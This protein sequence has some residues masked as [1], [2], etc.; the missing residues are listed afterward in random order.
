MSFSNKILF[1][2]LDNYN[3]S[4]IS[5]DKIFK[6]LKPKNKGYISTYVNNLKKKK[7]CS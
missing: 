5:K 2:L 7:S 1:V 3:E 4:R 6:I